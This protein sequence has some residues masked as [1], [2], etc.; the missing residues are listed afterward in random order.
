MIPGSS[1]RARASFT[2]SPTFLVARTRSSVR[3]LQDLVGRR[4]EKPTI[5]DMNGVEPILPRS[6]S[7]T[8]EERFSS[9]SSL[10]FTRASHARVGP[11]VDRR[12]LD[13][14]VLRYG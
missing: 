1:S 14:V 2:K 13:V 4:F 11:H 8:L 9:S 10:T 7:A 12:E 6:V 3:T 5:A